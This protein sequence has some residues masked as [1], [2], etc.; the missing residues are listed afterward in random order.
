[1]AKSK[2]KLNDKALEEVSGGVSLDS[3]A[4]K[5]DL[6]AQKADMLEQKTDM[7]NQKVDMLMQKSDLLNKKED[8]KNKKFKFNLFD[9][10]FKKEK[11]V[12]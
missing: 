1:M 6:M 8:L 10:F 3:L 9:M 11:N 2:K 12:L 5:T 4:Q 7:L